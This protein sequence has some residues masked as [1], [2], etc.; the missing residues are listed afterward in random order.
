L[1]EAKE[2]FAAFRAQKLNALQLKVK[3][4]PPYRHL[5][6]NRPVGDVKIPVPPKRDGNGEELHKCEC[7]PESENPCSSD[8]DCLNRLMMIE[9]NPKTCN[10]GDKCCNQRFKK[11]EFARTKP[12]NTGPR[13][14]G[15]KALENIKQ[16]QFVIEY[17]GELISERECEERLLR[18]VENNEHCFY[19]LTMDKNCVIDAGPSGNLARFMNHSCDPNC[20]TVKWIVEGTYRMGLFAVRDINA[21]EISR[22]V[23]VNHF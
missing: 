16:G 18:K 5:R 8:E 7:A 3:K 11:R 13:G 1:K 12:F 19:F 14:W 17:A 10:A 23:V 2:A 6:A 9:C 20:K 21:G 22:L 15:L 4:W